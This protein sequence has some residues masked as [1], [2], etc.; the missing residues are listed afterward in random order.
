VIVVG[1]RPLTEHVHLGA[2]EPQDRPHRAGVCGRS[3]QGL[4]FSSLSRQVPAL[5]AQ[6]GGDPVSLALRVD[7]TK[8]DRLALQISR[9]GFVV[10]ADRIFQGDEVRLVQWLLVSV[11]LDLRRGVG[12]A[13][14]AA[15]NCDRG[16]DAE[17][18]KA[19]H[20]LKLAGE[21]SPDED[22][23]PAVLAGAGANESRQAADGI[24]THDLL[25]GKQTL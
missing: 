25:H 8:V 11:G 18:D 5:L 15:G 22:A 10:P 23:P 2:D 4:Q 20:P 19:S 9:S 16:K 7:T 12:G 13:S 17:Q 14:T 6:K 1:L 3:F 24:R 21:C